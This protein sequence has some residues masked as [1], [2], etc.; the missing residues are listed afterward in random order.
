MKC[1][2]ISEKKEEVALTVEV[3]NHNKSMH[4]THKSS[5]VALSLLVSL[6]EVGVFDVSGF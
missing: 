1:I 6:K 3:V 4:L 5:G 2:S